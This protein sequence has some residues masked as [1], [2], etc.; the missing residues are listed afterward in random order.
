MVV[1]RE[2]GW[3]LE[4][5]GGRLAE[6]WPEAVVYF[7]EGGIGLLEEEIKRGNMGSVIFNKY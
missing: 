4:G 3:V 5:G 2:N 7:G 6:V 1:V